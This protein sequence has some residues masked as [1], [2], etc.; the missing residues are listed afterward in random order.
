MSKLDL[1]IQIPC[2]IKST[3]KKCIFKKNYKIWS[4][5]DLAQLQ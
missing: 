2:T 5:D 4:Q 1:L 3:I